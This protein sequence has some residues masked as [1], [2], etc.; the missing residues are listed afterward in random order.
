MK[1]NVHSNLGSRAGRPHQG[2]IAGHQRIT[3][4]NADIVAA[5]LQRH[6]YTLHEHKPIPKY[7][8][9]YMGARAVVLQT[10]NV[11]AA[12]ILSDPKV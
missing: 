4:L 9:E 12:Y 5:K 2:F 11:E 8:A 3:R 1:R 6:M 7:G 10:V